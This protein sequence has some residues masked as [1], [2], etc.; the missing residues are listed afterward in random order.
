MST[1]LQ[2]ISSRLFSFLKGIF[3]PA[4]SRFALT[5][6][7]RTGPFTN[8]I[9]KEQH[10]HGEPL[11]FA[12]VVLSVA[13]AWLI[14]S[15]TGAHP[16]LTNTTDVAVLNWLI[17]VPMNF[18]C[19]SAICWNIRRLHDLGRS[20]SAMVGPASY[21][22]GIPAAALTPFA[23]WLG[24]QLAGLVP[25]MLSSLPLDPL[26]GVILAAI[27]STWAYFA[28]VYMPHMKRWHRNVTLAPG[29]PGPNRY[30]P[31]PQ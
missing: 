6:L 19:Y 15:L 9:A 16:T 24:L 7:G 10:F 1:P 8:E 30:G 25:A 20:A 18:F 31:A 17:V 29:D 11:F 23:V 13:L 4:R 28:L 3:D 5:P 26:I 14:G 22:L 2:R 21:L 12:S 27:S